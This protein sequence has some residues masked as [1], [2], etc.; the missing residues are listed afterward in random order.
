MDSLWTWA[1]LNK[2]IPGKIARG[3]STATIYHA[4]W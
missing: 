2:F 3:N 1:S 4:K